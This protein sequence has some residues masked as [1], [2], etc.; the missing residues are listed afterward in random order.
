MYDFSEQLTAQKP[1]GGGVPVG[2]YVLLS[3]YLRGERTYCPFQVGLRFSTNALM[4]SCAS[5]AMAFFTMTSLA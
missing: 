3:G 5:L 2:Y 4:P 1:L